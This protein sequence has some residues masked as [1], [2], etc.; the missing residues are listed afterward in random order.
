LT[1]LLDAAAAVIFACLALLLI[2]F[3]P[4]ILVFFEHHAK[5]VVVVVALFD[6]RDALSPDVAKWYLHCCFQGH[7]WSTLL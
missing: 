1:G 5:E 4:L 7:W 6:T 3:Q 2:F